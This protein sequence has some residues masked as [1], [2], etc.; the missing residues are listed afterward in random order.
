MQRQNPQRFFEL[1][2][3]QLL[4][5]IA[6][7]LILILGITF[8]SSGALLVSSVGQINS[9]LLNVHVLFYLL[10][11]FINDGWGVV[12]FIVLLLVAIW[13]NML[14]AKRL[15]LFAKVVLYSIIIDVIAGSIIAAV[16]ASRSLGYAYGVSG[17]AMTLAGI[18]LTLA[19]YLV[20]KRLNA[21]FSMIGISF[22]LFS[23]AYIPFVYG[24]VMLCAVSIAAGVLA[25]ALAPHRRKA[26]NTKALISE[27][28]TTILII[29]DILLIAVLLFL[30]FPNN[31]YTSSGKIN[32]LA[33]YTGLLL[34]FLVAFYIL[35]KDGK[36]PK[37]NMAL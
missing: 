37:I 17:I 11:G 5:A 34:G 14:Y 22:L 32:T 13:T 19:S 2:L 25:L 26:V 29:C 16:I 24:N 21:A 10:S 4:T 12:G 1:Y 15:A 20:A 8:I 18:T 30:A 7:L 35:N 9:A 31:I 27:G 36:N 33:H 23:I 28:S 6:V 3:L